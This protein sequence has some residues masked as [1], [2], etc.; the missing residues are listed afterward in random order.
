MYLATGP[1]LQVGIN[2]SARSSKKTAR[3]L[4]PLP[5]MSARWVFSPMRWLP[6][7]GQAS[8]INV[9]DDNAQPFKLPRFAL[10]CSLDSLYPQGERR[11]H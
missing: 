7:I 2:P 9:V 8:I 4:L 11:L 10:L 1:R 6:V 5:V 3:R